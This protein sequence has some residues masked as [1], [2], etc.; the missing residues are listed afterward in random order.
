MALSFKRPAAWLPLL[1][2]LWLA[3]GPSSAHGAI[4]A[5]DLGAEFLKISLVKPGRTPISIVH[6]EMSKRKTTAAVAIINGDRLVGE[7]AAAL[8]ARYPDKV[9]TR[10][11]DM[12]GKGHD[13]PSLRRTL[14]DA[15]LP[16]TVV[17]AADRTTVAVTSDGVSYSAEEL[18]V[19]WV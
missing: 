7:E 16:Y 15:H 13:D 10:L 17:P 11:R 2:L 18:V 14:Q 4:M 9:F 1:A 5:V 12:L 3:A 19:R 6:N 8:T